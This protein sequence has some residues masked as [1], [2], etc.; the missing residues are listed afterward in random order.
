MC[1]CWMPIANSMG[2]HVS[3][4]RRCNKYPATGW[5]PI[6]YRS[7]RIC[8]RRYIL[9]HKMNLT[10]DDTLCVF[11][12]FFIYYRIFRSDKMNHKGFVQLSMYKLYIRLIVCSI[13]RWTRSIWYFLSHQHYQMGFTVFDD[14]LKHAKTNMVAAISRARY[15]LSMTIN[16]TKNNKYQKPKPNKT[17][18]KEF[19]YVV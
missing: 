7:V 11:S 14:R 4:I 16:M 2:K 18:K 19:C 12:F 1:V 10:H 9:N 13:M 6:D 3:F 8:S 17:K 15:R 5:Y